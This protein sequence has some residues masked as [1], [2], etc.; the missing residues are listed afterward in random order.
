M[1]ESNN[2]IDDL[3]KN[4]LEHYALDAPMEVWDRID[5]KRTPLYKLA[6]SFRQ[7]QKTYLSALAGLLV[8]GGAAAM[9]LFP[10][11]GQDTNAATAGPSINSEIT[12]YHSGNTAHSPATTS[13][14]DGASFVQP[15]A[16]AT[17]VHQ[18]TTSENTS[19]NTPAAQPAHSFL[20]TESKDPLIATALPILIEETP[21]TNGNETPVKTTGGEQLVEISPDAEHP[22][23]AETSTA[24]VPEGVI[25]PAPAMVENTDATEEKTTVLKKPVPS[26]FSM[27]IAF[28]YDFVNRAFQSNDGTDISSYRDVRNGA[29]KTK[30]AF[31]AQARINYA[32]NDLFT[33]RSGLS[34]SRINEQMNF[35]QPFYRQE[36]TTR[37]VTGVVIDPFTGPK[38]IT[39]SVT[40][41][42]NVKY[43]QN[44]RSDNAYTFVDI[45]V[46]LQYRFIN[47][48][49]FNI[50]INAGVMVNLAFL[51]KGNVISRNT[52]ETNNLSG[53]NNP[54]KSQAGVSVTL[55]MTGAYKISEKIDLLVEPNIRYGT[56]SVMKN[57]YSVKQNFTTIQV[58]TGIRY[59]F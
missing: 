56:G 44:V 53:I 46:S 59:S 10:I 15:A 1:N 11:Q 35:S 14:T 26:R 57:D 45:P 51:Q 37:N 32:L 29:E 43:F 33:L 39:Y 24:V 30:A 27:E 54:Y 3:F 36:I 42:A 47:A 50:G 21:S 19:N 6:N 5:R 28:S 2:R 20:I 4:R 52:L 17:P 31:T 49:R 23:T 58:F 22:M 13:K 41:T 12:A 16:Y 9:L 38:Q 55:G 25:T 48:D 8:T 40:D 18:I 34:F 7:Y